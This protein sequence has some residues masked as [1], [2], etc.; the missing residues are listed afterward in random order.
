MSKVNSYLR[1]FEE[2]QTM[3]KWLHQRKADGLPLPATPDDYIRML[4][5]TQ[6]STSRQALKKAMG[7]VR[8]WRAQAQ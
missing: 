5:E 7:R 4:I 6:R 2:M 8:G 3:H 1:S